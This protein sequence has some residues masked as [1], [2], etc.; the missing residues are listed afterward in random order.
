VHLEENREEILLIICDINMP[1]M[2]GLEFKKE[3]EKDTYLSEKSIPF[4]FFPVMTPIK[5]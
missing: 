1:E 4:V 3:I 2:S 5:R